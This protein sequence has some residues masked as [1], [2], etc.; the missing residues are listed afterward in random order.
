LLVVVAVERQLHML[1]VV[2]AVVDIERHQ[3]F[4][5]LLALQLRLL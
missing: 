5:F 1:A 3:D 2:V 4:L